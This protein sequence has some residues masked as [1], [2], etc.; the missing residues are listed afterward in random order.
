MGEPRYVVITGDLLKKIA[1]GRW[2]VGELLPTEPELAAEYGVSR[3]CGGR[4]GVWKWPVSSPGIPGPVPG[5]NARRR[6][7]RSPH[8]SGPSGI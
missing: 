5:W 3:H 6:S 2:G 1:A 4:C 7:P 8:S